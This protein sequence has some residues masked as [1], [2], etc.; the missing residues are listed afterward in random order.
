MAK[1]GISDDEGRTSRTVYRYVI[2][3]SLPAPSSFS[4]ESFHQTDVAIRG[5]RGTHCIMD[6]GNLDHCWGVGGR[7]GNLICIIMT[8][9]LHA[10]Y[11]DTELVRDRKSV[12]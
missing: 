7:G 3:S 4:T 11:S 6:N 12:V 8:D 2:C 5:P 1:I 9:L 10:A